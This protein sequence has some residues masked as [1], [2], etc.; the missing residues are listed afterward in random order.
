MKKV[1]IKRGGR[2]SQSRSIRQGIVLWDVDNESPSQGKLMAL[3]RQAIKCIDEGN[4]NP[5]EKTSR[6]S[7]EGKG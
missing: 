6:E 5:R 2:G 3:S 4:E 7:S 1:L